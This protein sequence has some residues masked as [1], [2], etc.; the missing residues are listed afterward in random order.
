VKIPTILLISLVFLASCNTG[1]EAI[2]PSSGPIVEAVYAS[3]VIKADHQYN[4]FPQVNGVLHEVLVEAGDTVKKDQPLFVL[5][6]I[7]AQLNNQ[8]ALI[9]LQLSKA[10]AS[11]KSERI[12]ELEEQVRV[13]E[14]AFELDSTLLDR[15][16]R[17]WE[18]GIGSQL[19][20]EQRQLALT[21]SQ[22]GLAGARSRLQDVRRQLE[23]AYQQAEVNYRR[24]LDALSEYVVKSAIDG[25]IYNIEREKGELITT[26]TPLG[27][28]GDHSGFLIEMQVDEFDIARIALN[29][30]VQVTLESYPDEVFEAKVT[31]INPAMNARS[32]TFVVEARFGS[33]PP[34]LYPFLTAE[35]NIVVKEK[36]EGADHSPVIPHRQA[37][38]AARERRY[39]GSTD[40]NQRSRKS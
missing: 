40:G 33:P 26:Q 28:I 23:S 17:L 3:G 24:S 34:R 22:T 30:R 5:R 9:L 35:A 4:V 11:P 12:T 39:G 38:R 19:E 6:D 16:T 7:Q 15:Q 2:S 14:A 29:Q 21:S 25:M 10:Q 27:L 13:A 37:I 8:N 18:Q 1:P 32:R 31:R 20:L 36:R